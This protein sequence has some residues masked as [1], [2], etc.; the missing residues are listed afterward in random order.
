M[1]NIALYFEITKFNN[2]FI[3]KCI[4]KLIILFFIRLLKYALIYEK[5][6]SQKR[7]PGYEVVP[8]ITEF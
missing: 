3:I 1:E 4:F 7:V 5:T 6:S 2:C 8:D